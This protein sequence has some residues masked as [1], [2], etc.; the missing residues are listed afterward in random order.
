LKELGIE[1]QGIEP[2]PARALFARK[3]LSIEVVVSPYNQDLF[4]PDTFDA[5]IFIQVLEHMEHPLDSLT[6]AK[7][8]LKPKGLLVIDVPSFNNSRILA[9]R[10]T[11]LS[12]LVQ[13]D[14]IPS[15]CYYFTRR[16]LVKLAEKAGFEALKAQTGRYSVKFSEN[17]LTSALDR[18]ANALGIGGITLYAQ[19]LW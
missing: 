13:R 3:E 14:F 16:T 19:K 18:V 11:R 2:D 5:I 15:H 17:T 12:S 7:E 9:Y 10:L 8:H 1:A 6:I 4:A